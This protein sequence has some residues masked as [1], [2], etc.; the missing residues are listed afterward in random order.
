[1]GKVRYTVVRKGTSLVLAATL[2]TGMVPAI[3][4][5]QDAGSGDAPVAVQ[6]ENGFA[7]V[8]GKVY[9]V[10]VKWLKADSDS[11]SMMGAYFS[12]T[13]KAVYQNGEYV[14]SLTA[15]ESGKSMGVK[16][17]SAGSELPYADNADGTRTFTVSTLKLDALT[18]QVTAPG[19][20]MMQSA[21]AV[22]D[23][24]TIDEGVDIPSYE[25]AFT[26]YFKGSKYDTS[27][28]FND[29][30]K[31]TASNGSYIIG[32]TAKSLGEGNTLGD[33]T[34]QGKKVAK[35]VNEDGSATYSIPVSSITG[36]YD[37][38]FGYTVSIPNRGTVTNLH[39]FQLVVGNAT[40]NV[41]FVD[42]T[43]LTSEIVK[44]EAVEQ[45]SKTDEAFSALQLAI[46]DAYAT[47]DAADA[48][49]A[50]IAA[51]VNAITAAVETFNASDDKADPGQD[52]QKVDKTALNKAIAAAKAIEQGKKTDEAFNTLKE[53]IATA[54][55]AAANDKIPQE[56]VDAVTEQ[57][58]AAVETFNT[59]KDAETPAPTP[60]EEETVTTADGF[61]LVAGKE[62]T[63]PVSFINATTGEQ[64]TAANFMDA[65]ATVSYADGSYSVTVTPNAQGKQFLTAMTYGGKAVVQNADGSFTI[66]G[67]PAISKDITV[68]VTMPGG[69]VDMGVRLDTT[70]LPTASGEPVTPQP[71]AG[72]NN[73]NNDGNGGATTD[74][75]GQQAEQGFQVG[76]TYQV[77]ASWLKHNSTEESM[78]AKYFGDTALVRPQSDGTFK[79]SFSATSEGADHIISLAYNGS[80]LAKSGNQYTVSIPKA[81]SD[82]VVPISMTIKE[83]EQLGGGAQIADMHLKLSQAKDLGTGQDNVVA[84]SSKILSQTGDNAAG[85]AGAAAVAAVAA[86]A[87]VVARRR[88][89][90]R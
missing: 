22:F 21:R 43:G 76:H 30:V 53:A 19:M 23:T 17:L 2:A 49:D 46:A 34:Y 44:A 74:P 68:S 50:S 8:E 15:N 33:V 86:G 20:P 4:L 57:L 24:S 41:S 36:T 37:I 9:T 69:T 63:L 65:T 35:T 66:S 5:A 89:Q 14:V 83:M 58:K 55:K 73:G 25:D 48:T 59:S 61:K 77:P 64:S 26:L 71:P 12:T 13:A 7:P 6:A 62:Y 11:S 16:L 29:K 51:G 32:L 40:P 52:E 85:V 1:M 84:S 70:S 79:V 54:E 72:N 31:V 60:S 47:V 81:D 45:G 90:R 27:R 82:T 42:R 38:T 56:G 28:S 78:A 3:A 67:V 80:D 18:L 39:P 75:N 88:M 10:Q 87:A